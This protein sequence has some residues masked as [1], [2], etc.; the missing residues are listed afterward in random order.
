MHVLFFCL[1][2][3]SLGVQ[4]QARANNEKLWISSAVFPSSTQIE[5]LN[6]AYAQDQ[7]QPREKPP[8]HAGRIAAEIFVGGA[9]GVGLGFVGVRVG[10]SLADCAKG[11]LDLCGLGE[12]I[13]GG[14]IGYVLGSAIGVYII[15]TGGNETGS[16]ATTL[17]GSIVFPIVVGGGAIVAKDAM[18]IN[19]VKQPWEAIATV[20]AGAL[21]PIG[22][23]IGFNRF[24]RYDAS[25]TT[26]SALININSGQ[27]ALAVPQLTF[28]PE[29]SINLLKVRF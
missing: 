17:V 21:P 8:L 27:T 15:G 5:L 19:D 20:A 6:L 12:G 10:Y 9:G 29:P 25:F 3:T 13:I 18:N 7:L 14:M 28:R 4:T 24:R 2:T 11:F 26:R 23:T 16:F 1:L 22:A